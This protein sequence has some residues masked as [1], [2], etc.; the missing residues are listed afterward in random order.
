MNEQMMN[1][2]PNNSNH[3]RCNTCEARLMRKGPKQNWPSSCQK[4]GW[5]LCNIC[6]T[7]KRRKQR[8][9]A[10]LRAQRTKAYAAVAPTPDLD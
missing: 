4:M 5:Y 8:T 7:L 9:D 6:L 1:F 3:R 10:A 2:N